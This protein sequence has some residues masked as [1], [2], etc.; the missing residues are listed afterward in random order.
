MSKIY[1]GMDRGE[2]QD[3]VDR[4][5]EAIRLLQDA[6]DYLNGSSIDYLNTILDEIDDAI[7]D[8]ADELPDIQAALADA[9]K[10]EEEEE[11]REY[12]RSVI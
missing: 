10:A 4:A 12:Y 2:L 7:N 8:I 5:E 6:K 3:N 1:Q 9:N 11:R